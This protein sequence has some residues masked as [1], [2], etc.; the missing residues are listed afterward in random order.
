MGRCHYVG[1]VAYDP[2]IEKRTWRPAENAVKIP[3]LRA[4][5]REILPFVG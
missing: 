3:R 5:Q 2:S 4:I 1:S